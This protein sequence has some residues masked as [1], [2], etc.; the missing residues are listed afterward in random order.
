LHFVNGPVDALFMGGGSVLVYLGFLAAGLSGPHRGA[1][2]LAGALLWI[3]NHPHFC[4]TLH[5]LY[6]SRENIR[7]Y[8][9]TAL[10]VP[11]LVAA[12]AVASFASPDRV[13][14]Y[15]I[16]LFLLWSPYHFAAQSLGLTLVYARRAGLGLRPLERAAL[17]ASVFGTFLF[18]LALA[19]TGTLDLTYFDVPYPHLGL[20][21]WV[22]G[23][24]RISM[25]ACGG[26]FVATAA[27][28]SFRTRRLIPPIV[29]VP[30]LAQFVWFVPGAH[31]ASY[32]EFV[33]FFHS[34]QYLFVA[35]AVH[36]RERRD[37]SGAPGPGPFVAVQSARW[38]A[39]NV[40]GGV[41]L[42]WLLPRAAAAG[43]YPQGFA[44]PVVIAAVQIHHFFVDGVIW[45]L[46]N[47]RVASPLLV[48]LHDLREPARTETAPA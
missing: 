46:R 12:G 29:L 27:A 18:P 4:A 9:V 30:A 42:F 34:L 45:K 15:F 7:E 37:L 8:P 17:S 43:G 31:L 35:W 20:P 6:G 24:A 26:L 40:L 10:G 36:L 14:P 13:A 19:E 2:A 48:S 39:L 28:V 41:A 3:V 38:M 1:A 33:P 23:T 16:K 11:F 47:P 32:N 22:A 5:R 21:A 44:E 25:Y